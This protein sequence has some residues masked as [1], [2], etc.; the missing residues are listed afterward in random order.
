LGRGK[1]KKGASDE[2]KKTEGSKKNGEGVG[3]TGEN[4][5]AERGTRRRSQEAKD[6]SKDDAEK[7]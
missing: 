7:E 5:V 6:L 1:N 4:I 2:A 3:S